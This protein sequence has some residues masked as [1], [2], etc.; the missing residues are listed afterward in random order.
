MGR[1]WSRT[2]RSGSGWHA[3]VVRRLRVP[4][5]AL[6]AVLPAACADD[7]GSA[8]PTVREPSDVATS[9]PS[10]D[11]AESPAPGLPD[12]VAVAE[13][14]Y[15]RDLLD[16]GRVNIVV[17]REGNQ[18]FVVHRHQ[19]R[20][21]GFEPAPAED[22]RIVIPPD[23]QRVAIQAIFGEVVDCD[24]PTPLAATL[25]VEFTV[26]D[27][28][29]VRDGAIVLDETETLAAIRARFCTA[30]RV[31]AENELVLGEPTLD[32]E[33]FTL[34]L[35]VTRRSGDAQLVV[36]AIQGTVLFGVE[37]PYE[38]GAPERTL[39]SGATELVLPL[40]FD[41]NRC[42]PHAVAETTKKKGLTLWI[43]VDGATAQ[44]VD[45]D[46]SSIEDELEE[47]LNRCKARTG[48]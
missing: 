12:T 14:G 40:T 34:D 46:I 10:T 8:A 24:A 13:L 43:G 16:R 42:D 19:L 2:D 30:R 7:G 18:S 48:Q 9:P 3:G 11:G 28:P 29:A 5:L 1:A 15:P 39:E 35:A 36:D 4:A 26:G 23:G 33:T 41:V 6:L 21:D 32:A 47:I 20:I 22:R 37:S 45:V 44:P 17:T 27:D 25:A 31:L 38:Q